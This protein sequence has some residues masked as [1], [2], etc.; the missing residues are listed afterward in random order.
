MKVVMVNSYTSF[1]K[2]FD[3]TIAGYKQGLF[4]LV[5]I[6]TMKLYY[7]RVPYPLDRYY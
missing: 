3:Y 4:A 6:T 1:L 7:W 2:A 5:G